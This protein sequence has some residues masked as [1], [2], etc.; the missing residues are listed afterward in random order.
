ML[1]MYFVGGEKQTCGKAGSWQTEMQ[2]PARDADYPA[3]PRALPDD[4]RGGL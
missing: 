4:P 2:L 3:G 1:F